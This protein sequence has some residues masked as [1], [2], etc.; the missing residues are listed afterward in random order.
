MKEKH[1][2]RWEL[3]LSISSFIFHVFV[4]VRSFS[5]LSLALY[6]T[7][8]TTEVLGKKRWHLSIIR[9]PWCAHH[10]VGRKLIAPRVQPFAPLFHDIRGT[11]LYTTWWR[12][13]GFAG[14]DRHAAWIQIYRS[15]KPMICDDGRDGM[16]RDALMGFQ[17]RCCTR[18]RSSMVLEKTAP[19]AP[20]AG[21]R[22][23]GQCR[24]P[25]LHRGHPRPIHT[26]VST[27]ASA[28]M[29]YTGPP[30]RRSCTENRL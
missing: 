25:S 9:I 20:L 30:A 8:S 7:A 29:S 28:G 21:R 18:R 14:V 12:E 16:S 24:T 10:L 2:C 15:I 26:D 3:L 1:L 23:E 4:L 19:T 27:L 17:R 6:S 11:H 5:V 13:R 22:R